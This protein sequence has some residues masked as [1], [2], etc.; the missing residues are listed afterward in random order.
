MVS[1]LGQQHMLE[2][3][4]QGEILFFGLYF[5]MTGLHALH[6]IVGLVIIGVAMLRVV[7]GTVHANGPHCLKMPAYTGTLWM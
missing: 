1:G 4:S 6:I 5:I 2:T 7:N 3:M